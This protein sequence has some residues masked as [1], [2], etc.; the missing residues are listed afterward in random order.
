M[1]EPLNIVLTL[2]GPLSGKTMVINQREFI[3]GECILKGQPEN[4]WGAVN[5]LRTYYNAQIKDSEEHKAAQKAY[6]DSL[7]KSKPDDDLELLKSTLNSL[8]V[9]DD[10]QWTRNGKP[11]LT[12]LTSVVKFNVTKEMVESINPNLRRSV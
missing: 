9:S 4:V 1:S 5:Y 2:V 8:D 12:Y 3:N 11:S 6:E 10:T 7:K